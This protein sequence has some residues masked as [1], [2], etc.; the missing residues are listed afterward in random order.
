MVF[1]NALLNSDKESLNMSKPINTYQVIL[2]TGRYSTTVKKIIICLKKNKKYKRN[3][4]LGSQVYNFYHIYWFICM[5]IHKTPVWSLNSHFLPCGFQ[6]SK[7]MKFDRKCFYP[8]GHF[9]NQ[10]QLFS[11]INWWKHVTKNLEKCS[12]IFWI[13]CS[14]VIIE[15][16]P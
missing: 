15:L 2:C 4:C 1:L 5:Y 7:V 3:S 9:I 12:Y 11:K 6:N 13:F 10:P 14:W 16:F 8:L